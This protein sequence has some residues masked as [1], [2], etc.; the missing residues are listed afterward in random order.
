MFRNILKN[1]PICP[2]ASPRRPPSWIRRCSSPLLAFLRL[3]PS[4]PVPPIS[5]TVSPPFLHPII[6][7]LILTDPSL[8]SGQSVV[9]AFGPSL[10]APSSSSSS[11][12]H[13]S[14]I[15]PDHSAL[16]SPQN[17]P[18]P[19]SLLHQ[20]DLSGV[21]QQH[22]NFYPSPQFGA[23]IPL[24]N[25]SASAAPSNSTITTSTT[26]T[27]LGIAEKAHQSRQPKQQHKGAG[28]NGES[29]QKMRDQGDQN[30]IRGQIRSRVKESEKEC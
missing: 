14:A 28:N 22:A 25:Q 18:A 17:G 12:S 4:S 6:S 30:Q 29:D 9:G 16:L 27:N 23:S 20:L 5:F 24:G 7:S 15:P 26:S 21:P 19:P 1:P 8:P 13:P 2:R 11:S 3:P 10:G